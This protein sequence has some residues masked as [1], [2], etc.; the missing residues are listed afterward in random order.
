[1]VKFDYKKELVDIIKSKRYGFNGDTKEWSKI[2]P[3]NKLDEEKKWLT[4]NIYKGS[5]SGLIEKI[6]LIDKYKNR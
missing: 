6:T 4:E 5:F 1:M 3:E 2:I